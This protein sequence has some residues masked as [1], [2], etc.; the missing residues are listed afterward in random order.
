VLFT[1]GLGL[2]CLAICYWA[3]DIRPWHGVWTKPFLIFGRNAI[4]AYI[5]AFFFGVLPYG[6]NVRVNGVMQNDHDY[7]F[8]RFFAPLGSPSFTS[9]LFSLTFVAVFLIPIWVM[10]HKRIFLKI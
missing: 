4:T 2:I 9:L 6:F 3:T 5:V 7:I 1:A 10:D 8:Q